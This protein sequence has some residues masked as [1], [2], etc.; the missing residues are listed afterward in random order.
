MSL[1]SVLTSDT[2]IPYTGT[3]VT[4]LT[5]PINAGKYYYRI[6]LLATN[7]YSIST[8]GIQLALQSGN[9]FTNTSIGYYNDGVNNTNIT[10]TATTFNVASL[11]TNKTSALPI[12]AEGVVTIGTNDTLL[13]KGFANTNFTITWE[14]GSGVFL[15]SL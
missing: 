12:F 13:I 7:N 9:T 11:T 15:T 3:P 10:G 6:Y 1:S 8:L 5:V 4:F 2:A 14:L